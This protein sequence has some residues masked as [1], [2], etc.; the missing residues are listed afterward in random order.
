MINIH[1][2]FTDGS[3]LSY[4]EGNKAEAGFNTNCLSFFCFDTKD[5]VKVIKKDGSY[6]L[7]SELLGYSG[8]TDRE[9]REAH[10]LEKMLKANS[11]KWKKEGI[12]KY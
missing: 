5:D 8:Y 9:I 11:F 3:E 10:N 7:K 4:I 2:D 1:F 12:F 6:I